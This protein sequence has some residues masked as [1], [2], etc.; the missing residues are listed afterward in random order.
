MIELH[1]LKND[2]LVAH[3]IDWAED[4][5]P[6]ER[7]AMLAELLTRFELQRTQM[8]TSKRAR[9]RLTRDMRLMEIELAKTRARYK[10][11]TEPIPQA[12]DASY[13][14]LQFLERHVLELNARI[15][16]AATEAHRDGYARGFGVGV[17]EGKTRV[18]DLV[19]S[20]L[21]QTIGT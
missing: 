13:R 9:H 16:A 3:I 15:N 17:T 10:A 18:G 11:A 21:N 1:R 6:D 5:T 14:R 20:T 2:A 12:D 4:A 19:V 7:L 8:H